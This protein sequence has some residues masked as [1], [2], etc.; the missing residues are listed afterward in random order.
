MSPKLSIPS[1][2]RVDALRG[3]APDDRLAVAVQL[4]GRVRGVRGREEVPAPLDDQALDEQLDV[5]AGDY[6]VPLARFERAVDDEHVFPVNFIF[7]GV[8]F[9]PHDVGGEL[10][11]DQP[12]VEVD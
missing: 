12:L 8:A 4:Y 10:N 9:D 5:Y 6:D 11:P 3:H 1:P 7:H 2:H